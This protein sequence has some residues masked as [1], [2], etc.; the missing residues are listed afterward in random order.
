MEMYA[1][2]QID[3]LTFEA[4][5]TITRLEEELDEAMD[6]QF[7]A[8]PENGVSVGWDEMAAIYRARASAAEAE[9]ARLRDALEGERDEAFARGVESG[10]AINSIAAFPI[11]RQLQE[12][13]ARAEAAEAEVERLKSDVDDLVRAGSDEAT[14]NARLRGALIEITQKA[15]DGRR[16]ASLPAISRIAAEALT[17]DLTNG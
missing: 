17:G 5:A 7:T 15:R 13:T 14:E 3:R 4:A 8:H 6:A 9:N 12:Q 11:S 2:P 10:K 1:D 16:T